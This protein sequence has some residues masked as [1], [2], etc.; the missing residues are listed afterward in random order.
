MISKAK[1]KEWFIKQWAKSGKKL[2]MG[3]ACI[4][5]KSLDDLP[6][7]VIGKAIARV[8]VKKHIA[9]YEKAINANRR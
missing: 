9:Y 8:P 1:H 5:F 3:K 4:R 2:D 7:E 6:L